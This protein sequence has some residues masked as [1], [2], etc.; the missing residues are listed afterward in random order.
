[1]GLGSDDAPAGVEE[2]ELSQVRQ[3][4]PY[5]PPLGLAHIPSKMS[6]EL[7]YDGQTVVVTGAGGG[8]SCD[9]P[10]D[11]Q[12]KGIGITDHS[13]SLEK[14]M[15]CSSAREEPMSSSTTW[16]ALSRARESQ[17]R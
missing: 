2:R 14:R 4:V 3:L 11:V 12:A 13:L 6:N 16:E 5:T 9:N 10:H 7:R 8:V 17:R 15:R 1:M